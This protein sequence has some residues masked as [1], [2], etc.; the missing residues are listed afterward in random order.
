[1]NRTIVE[2]RL[3]YSPKFSKGDIGMNRTIVE[4]RPSRNILSGRETA[5]YESNHSGIETEVPMIVYC[6]SC[7]Y[8][9]NHS[10]IETA[11]R[12]LL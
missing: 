6:P 3:K 11:C 9:S 1:M 4:L 5:L 10:G 2:L 8:E 12:M 7:R